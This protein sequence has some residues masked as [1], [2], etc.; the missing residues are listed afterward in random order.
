MAVSALRDDVTDL[1]HHREALQ[2]LC[3]RGVK[4]ADPRKA[5][6]KQSLEQIELLLRRPG[7]EKALQCLVRRGAPE[8]VESGVPFR[9]LPRWH[10]EQHLGCPRQEL[11]AD[12]APRPGIV[13][14]IDAG[15]R[16]ADHGMADDMP[17]RIVRSVEEAKWLVGEAEDDVQPSRR[18]DVLAA[19][20]RHPRKALVGRPERFHERPKT[21]TRST[22]DE[23]VGDCRSEL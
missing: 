15:P 8:I 14:Q 21:W 22:V 4:T 7:S 18:Q 13:L 20:G 19:R 1:G 17:G 9:Q 2:R 16:A 11:S 23:H 5:R 10:P 12:G 3:H 6:C